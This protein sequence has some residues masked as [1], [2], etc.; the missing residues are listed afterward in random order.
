M[1]GRSAA[2][3]VA[4]RE[5][6]PS[7]LQNGRVKPAEISTT[8]S[9][10][11]LAQF[12]Q[13]RLAALSKDLYSETLGQM[14]TELLSLVLQHANGNQ[15]EAARI[16]GITRGSLRNKIRAHGILIDQVVTLDS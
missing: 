8:K 7:V 1:L 10:T 14:E 5:L 6:K 4:P 3:I 13:E 16:L 9:T 12:I 11:G 2:R 15:S